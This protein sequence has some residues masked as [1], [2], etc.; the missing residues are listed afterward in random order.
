MAEDGYPIRFLQNNQDRREIYAV[1]ERDGAAYGYGPLTLEQVDTAL[2]GGPSR[3]PRL[4]PGDPG[5]AASLASRTGEF[6]DLEDFYRFYGYPPEAVEWVEQTEMGSLTEPL[7]TPYQEG[8]R[9]VRDVARMLEIDYETLYRG[10]STEIVD[11]T[12]YDPEGNPPFHRW[13]WSNWAIGDMS[14]WRAINP[15]SYRFKAWL[16][17]HP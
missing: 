16:S 2:F 14:G 11:P 12:S 10:S 5:L 6:H 17:F 7:Y 3:Q 4:G 1:V 15:R 9:D 13:F 8:G